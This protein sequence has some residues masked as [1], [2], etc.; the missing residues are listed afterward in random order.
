M[1]PVEAL[2]PQ[3]RMPG[4]ARRTRHHTRLLGGERGWTD[5]PFARDGR[6]WGAARS[7]PA[8]VYHAAVTNTVSGALTTF[9]IVLLCASDHWV[10]AAEPSA[11]AA[12]ALTA[13]Q[14]VERIKSHVGVP[15]QAETVDTFKAGD[16]DTRI[17][18]VAVTMMAT[19][20]VLQRAVKS[21]HNLVITHEPTFYDHQ[22]P[23]EPLEKARDTV[24]A[25]KMA[26][27]RDHHLVVWR[28][29]DHWH[30]R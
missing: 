22:D 13:A 1:G 9:V 2:L 27:I 8:L 7:S 25:A 21:G 24:F 3:S 26:F 30:R 11:Q 4:S 20:D 28:F 16:P 19:L 12:T 5:T 29:H 18:G 14:I 10:A 17:T 6:N 23:T 15:W